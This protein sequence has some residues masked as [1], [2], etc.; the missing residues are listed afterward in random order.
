MTN[1]KTNE[2]LETNV[3]ELADLV[4]KL[5]IKQVQQDTQI[6]QILKMFNEFMNVAKVKEAK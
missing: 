2:E 3:Q 5:M 1:P 4:Q 6:E